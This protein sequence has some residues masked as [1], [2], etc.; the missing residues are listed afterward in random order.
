[1]KQVSLPFQVASALIM[2]HFAVW[3][4]M[5]TGGVLQAI[6]IMPGADFFIIVIAIYS[7]TITTGR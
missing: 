1:M 5:V 4:T 2:E 3:D 6:P 7:R